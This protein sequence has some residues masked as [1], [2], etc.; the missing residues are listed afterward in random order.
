M[1]L[2]INPDVSYRTI[3]SDVMKKYFFAGGIDEESERR[4]GNR[5]YCDKLC[6]CS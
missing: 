6:T 2:G 5:A 3:W 1:A 4:K